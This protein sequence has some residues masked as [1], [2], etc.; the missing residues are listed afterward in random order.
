MMTSITHI[1][2]I[3]GGYV[4]L[5]LAVAFAKH[6][7]VTVVTKSIQH[8]R[9]LV[10][11]YDRTKTFN[12]DELLEYPIIFTSNIRDASNAQIFIVTVPTPV[13][14]NYIPDLS[15]I[16]EATKS[17]ASVLKHHDIVIYEST[18]YIGCTE[19]FCVPI[20]EQFSGLK[21]NQ[22]FYCGF[23]PERIN[24]GDT[25]HTIYNVVKIIAGSTTETTQVMKEIYTKI[26]SAGLHIAPKIKVAEAS[27]LIENIQRD[28]NIALMNELSQIFHAIDIETEEVIQAASTKWN[29]LPFRPGL[30]GGHCI[31]V[32]PY[33]MIYNGEQENVPLPLITLSRSI[34]NSVS[35]YIID[36]TMKLMRERGIAPETATVLM[37]GITFKENCPDIRN[38]QS[39]I[40]FKKLQS[41]VKILH[42]HDPIADQQEI[43]LVYNIL[44]TS[45]DNILSNHYDVVI[46][47]VAHT[48]FKNIQIKDLLSS[49]KGIIVDLKGLFPKEQ[50]D[51]RL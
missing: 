51:F 10:E 1:C 41:K 25:E 5:P 18:V 47:S 45:I 31:G 43:Q 6:F 32:D 2:I 30:V 21:F 48:V 9:E 19:N 50:S 24:P 37:L 42:L 14:T 22:D 46:I 44:N 38:S 49:E 29:F 3:G 16:E 11:G 12:K 26:I 34:N 20:L 27:K 36:S 23:S 7:S 4:G 13:D 35:D 17:I 28:V 39:A 40:I 33:Y 15:P 8:A